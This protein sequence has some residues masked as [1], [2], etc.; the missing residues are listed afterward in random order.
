MCALTVFGD[1]TSSLGDLAR[2][3]CPRR[4]SR[5]TSNSRAVSGCHGSCRA[6]TAGHARELR[7]RVTEGGAAEPSAA[8]L[9]ASQDRDGLDVAVARG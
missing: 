9:T 1:E 5:A 2:S 8:V 4:P 6:A 3:S 7:R